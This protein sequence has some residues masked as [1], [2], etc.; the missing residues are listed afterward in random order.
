MLL[1]LDKAKTRL[2]TISG[3]IIL[4]ILGIVGVLANRYHDKKNAQLVLQPQAGDIYEMATEND[5][6]TLLKVGRVQGD[7][8]FVHINEY[9]AN[10]KS[11]LSQLRGEPFSPE[12]IA[13]T[14]Q[15]IRVMLKEGKILDV[16][17]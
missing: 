7:S 5:H 2:L 9:E 4:G 11:G 10:K 15:T 6:Y 12:E 1:R 17:R 16:D 3:L 8:V 13:F 14:K